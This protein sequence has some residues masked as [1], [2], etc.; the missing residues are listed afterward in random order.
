MR[1]DSLLLRS[2][3]GCHLSALSPKTEKELSAGQGHG[4]G[5]DQSHAGKVKSRLT[6]KECPD[7]EQLRQG[8]DEGRPSLGIRKKN[9][10][11]LGHQG[12]AGREG[13]S[14]RIHSTLISE[15]EFSDDCTEWAREA[16]AV[17]S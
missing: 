10:V 4:M 17:N 7:P 15:V 2:N 9:V 14:G 3:R 12:R 11:I 8:S 1:V 6:L 16:K 13:V 5:V